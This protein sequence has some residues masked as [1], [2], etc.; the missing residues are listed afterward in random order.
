MN[1]VE[2]METFHGPANRNNRRAVAKAYGLDIARRA[3]WGD[4]VTALSHHF[5][6]DK[7]AVCLAELISHIAVHIKWEGN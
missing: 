7:E 2:F 5:G 6:V 1:Y 3:S 4:F